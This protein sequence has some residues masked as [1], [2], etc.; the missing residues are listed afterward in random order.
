MLINCFSEH[1]GAAKQ[2]RARQ[3]FPF[4]HLQR[5]LSR[6]Q[7]GS[8]TSRN[9]DQKEE[10][11]LCT[12]PGDPSWLFVVSI[13]TLYNM[14][15]I[16]SRSQSS[17]KKISI[18]TLNWDVSRCRC[19]LRTLTICNWFTKRGDHAETF[20][21]LYRH[22]F[23]I[24]HPFFLCLTVIR[25][26]AGESPSHTHAHLVAILHRIYRRTFHI[27]FRFLWDCQTHIQ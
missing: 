3:S 7:L 17:A 23:E 6:T 2:R 1:T 26:V 9:V 21:F 25:A 27:N 16:E 14:F 11:S 22:F 20:F 18:V 12:P 4:L 13:F 15:Y 19:R 24:F 8:Q 10:V 5:L